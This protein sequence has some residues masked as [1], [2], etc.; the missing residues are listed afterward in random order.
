VAD[1]GFHKPP[2]HVWDEVEAVATGD[3]GPFEVHGKDDKQ[4]DGHAKGRHVAAKQGDGQEDLVKALLDVK[5]CDPAV[6]S[7]A[8]PMGML[9][10]LL[11]C[12]QSLTGNAKSRSDLKKHIVKNNIY[13][14]DIE[15]GAV[16]IARLRFWLAIIVDEKEPIPL[17]NLDYKIMQG[18]S[19]LESFEGEDLSCLTKT[20]GTL[21]DNAEIIKQLTDAINGFYIPSDHIAK[22]KIRRQISEK[23]LQLLKERQIAP[24][25]LKKLESIDL[26]SN[27]E[28]FLWH[29]W[30]SDVFNRPNDCNGFDIVIGNPPYRIVPKDD[31]FKALYDNKFSVAHGG[32]RNLYHLFFEQGILLLRKDGILSYITPDTYFSGNDTSALRKFFVDNTN[33]RNIVHYTEKDKVFENVTQAVAVAIM[34][35]QK[36]GEEFSILVDNKNEV[37]R[38]ENLTE[39]NNYIFK[40]SDSVIEQMKKLSRTFGDVCEGYKGDV[41]LA[42]KRDFFTTKKTTKALPLIRGIQISKYGYEAGNEYCSKEALSKDH[43]QKERIVFQEVANMGLAHRTK[44]TI[45]KDVIC[46]DSCNLIFSKMTEIDNRFILAVLNSKAVN[47]YFKFFNQTNH[48]P[49]GELKRIPFPFA[50]P[51]QQQPI[52]ALVDKIL[53]AKKDNPQADTSNDERKIDA[54]V[55]DLYGLNEEEIAIIE[56]KQ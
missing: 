23:V 55:Y 1:H 22:T 45:L 56:K 29:T 53:A 7:G 19:L 11:A 48:V 43:T 5:I 10:E 16:D 25:K 9:N 20:N 36:H 47:Y 33:I 44:G 38:Y 30:F 18:N 49:I 41:N 28:F 27:S 34:L 12:M 51:A 24:E 13:G 31:K 42:L 4:D 32:K 15:K 35:K 54:L 8:F 21:F 40:S 37:I 46:G 50:T 14:I 26:H 52:I 6:G 3:R 17:P 2:G 39:G